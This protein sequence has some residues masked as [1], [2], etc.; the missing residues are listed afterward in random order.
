[1]KAEEVP[2][3]DLGEIVVTEDEGRVFGTP[4]TVEV[5]SRDIEIKNAQTVDEALDFIPGVR[6]T[7]G[8]KNEPY[9]MIRGFNQDK[10]LILLDGIPIASPCYGYVDLNQIPTES[11]AKIKVI[12]SLISP[13]YGANTLGGVID[14][15]IKKPPESPYLEL[16]T[17]FSARH[18]QHSI[19]DYAA[20]SKNTSLW[21]SG[22]HRESD[23]FTLSRKFEA[24][25]NEN[26][27]LRENSFYKKNGFSLKVG[28]EK[29]E[30]HNLTTFFNYIDN[31]KGI[32]PHVSSSAPKYWR[33]AQW[34]RWM[35]ALTDE[36]QITDSLSIKGRIFY[37]KY[38]NTL[39]SYDDS[40]Y[41][42]QSNA[43]SWTSIYDEY[44]IGSNIYFVFD[45]TNKHL[46]KGA[47]NFKRDVHREQDDIGQPW[48][49]YEIE[50]YSFG[51]E[52]EIAM[53]EKFSLSGG[54][55]FDVFDQIKAYTGQRGDSVDSFNPVLTAS[56]VWRPQTSLYASASKRTRFPTIHQLFSATS[57]NQNLKEQ[58]NINYEV[59]IQHGF[60]KGATIELSCFYNDVKDLIDR[61]SKNDQ[62]L[63]TSQ[64]VFKGI[65]TTVRT[66]MGRYL[67]SCMGYVYLDARDKNPDLFGRSEEELS[68]T[69][70]HKA[71][72][73]LDYV[74]DFGLSCHLLG[75]YSGERYYYDSANNQHALGGY[76]VW[77]V[78]IS[79]KFLTHWEGS[80]YVENIFDRNYQEEEGYPQPGRTFSL[81][82]KAIF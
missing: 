60:E 41:T 77:S 82:I 38:D 58:K 48:E 5:T 35:V 74:T 3:F 51:L 70:K 46:L 63:N 30:K 49:M 55:S 62:F 33:F 75:S 50:T 9:V 52:D 10:A 19:V 17:G 54:A 76:S 31:E 53:S 11:I 78:K 81:N 66:P 40:S 65:E 56:Y 8:Q 2:T 37:D 32:P 57:G 4:S 6:L 68:Y 7:V 79:Q 24:G 43:S 29:F 59:G 39:K 12:K 23:G 80:I 45:P 47:V 25:L 71:D 14:I 73:G 20:K 61:A 64:A 21:F 34:R 69:P 27:G 18:T 26:G 22:S 72:F 13:L 16:S 28:L 44:A 36:S 15:V 42:T 67:S 1:M